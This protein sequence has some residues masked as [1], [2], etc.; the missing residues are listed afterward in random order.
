VTAH[1][2]SPGRTVYSYARVSLLGGFA[3]ASL[4]GV[5]LDVRRGRPVGL[6]SVEMR[7]I[8]DGLRQRQRLSLQQLRHQGARVPG[9]RR[10]DHDLLRAHLHGRYRGCERDYLPD[11]AADDELWRVARRR[12]RRCA[13]CCPRRRGRRSL[14]EQALVESFRRTP[15]GCSRS[16]LADR[17]CPRQR[18]LETESSRMRVTVWPVVVAT[19]V[20]VIA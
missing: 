17:M 12:R 4:V 20:L 14:I 19:T 1:G 2:G 3:A 18:P 5:G 15:R 16:P 9:R 8:A 11:G 10:V 13:G 6:L 7:Y